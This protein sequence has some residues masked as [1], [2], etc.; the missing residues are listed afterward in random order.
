M[1]RITCPAARLFL[2]N[3][4]RDDPTFASN[5]LRGVEKMHNIVAGDGHLVDL[6]AKIKHL[7]CT[8]KLGEVRSVEI[9][10]KDECIASIVPTHAHAH[11]HAHTYELLGAKNTYPCTMNISGGYLTVSIDA[12]PVITVSLESQ[13]PRAISWI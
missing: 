6:L 11:A 7:A 12:A 8:V 4:L 9:F 13:P 10:N 1:D 2:E 5:H 3:I